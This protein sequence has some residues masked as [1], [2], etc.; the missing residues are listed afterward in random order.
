M[1]IVRPRLEA[2]K[3]NLFASAPDVPAQESRRETNLFVGD[4]RCRRNA[5]TTNENEANNSGSPNRD[6][7]A[8]KLPVAVFVLGRLVA[9]GWTA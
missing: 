6:Q 4:L 7:N 5:L 2:T 1:G 9:K 3:S 8:E